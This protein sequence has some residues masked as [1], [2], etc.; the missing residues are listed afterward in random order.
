MTVRARDIAAIVGSVAL[1]VTVRLVDPFGLS[2]ATKEI[3]REVVNAIF[4]APWYDDLGGGWSGPPRPQDAAT[5]LLINDNT[6]SRAGQHWPLPATQLNFML[7]DLATYDPAAVVVDIMLSHERPD[8]RIP[9]SK[10]PAENGTGPQGASGADP[11]SQCSGQEVSPDS[12]F[13]GLAD[14]YRPLPSTAGDKPDQQAGKVPLLFAVP[15]P[16]FSAETACRVAPDQNCSLQPR[17]LLIPPLRRTATPT[18]VQ[19]RTAQQPETV[20]LEVTYNAGV[21]LGKRLAGEAA[22]PA[23]AALMA[24]CNDLVGRRPQVAGKLPGCDMIGIDPQ[25]GDRRVGSAGLHRQLEGKALLHWALRPAQ[26][27][28]YFEATSSGDAGDQGRMSDNCRLPSEDDKWDFYDRIGWMAKILTP[29]VFSQ[30]T[31]VAAD[32]PHARCTYTPTIF[33][34]LKHWPMRKL[35]DRKRPNGEGTVDLPRDL[36]EDRVVF[37]GTDLEIYSD[38][39]DAPVH[40]TLP[41]VYLHAMAFDNLLRFGDALPSP[42]AQMISVFDGAGSLSIVDF[43]EIVFLAASVTIGQLYARPRRYGQ[44]QRP[45]LPPLTLLGTPIVLVT[46]CAWRDWPAADWLLVT[47]ALLV[48]DRGKV[49]LSIGS[50][51]RD[52]G[53]YRVFWTLV[54]SLAMAATVVVALRAAQPFSAAVLVAMVAALFAFLLWAVIASGSAAWRAL[55]PGASCVDAREDVPWIGR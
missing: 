39:V 20:P 55:R 54:G 9:P 32:A 13:S 19:W 36:I 8:P 53:R 29:E 52:V 18:M 16:S 15:N 37:V 31:S 35:P 49:F 11:V 46:I 1:V 12:R 38:R 50:F 7:R 30:S 51:T 5:V 45:W 47:G 42:P 26:S 34:D 22:V 41:G 44:Q 27:Y 2:T 10:R 24:Y 6:L 40:G 25:Q 48:W 23:S 17:D 3:S 43:V 14:V 28:K 33:A 21:C 4:I